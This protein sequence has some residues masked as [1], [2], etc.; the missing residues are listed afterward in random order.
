MPA[1][2][3]DAALA[4]E[5]AVITWAKGLAAATNDHISDHD[6]RALVSE[7]EDAMGNHAWL[8]LD[9]QLQAAEA[10]LDAAG[11]GLPD[12]V[13]IPFAKRVGALARDRDV[14]RERADLAVA[15][16]AAALDLLRRF[17]EGDA[18]TECTHGGKK[19]RTHNMPQ[20]CIVGEARAL[21]HAGTVRTL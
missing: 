19:C 4:A 14:E 11:F 10:V 9:Q 8:V 1:V 2:K 18:H 6:R 20:P 17:L 13:E 16:E 5:Q 15:R 3:T 7:V 12:D 21:V